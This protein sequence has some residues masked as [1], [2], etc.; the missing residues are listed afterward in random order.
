[1]PKYDYE[2]EN[3][4]YK[5]IDIYQ[6]F[7]SESLIKCINCGQD[8]LNKIIY[9]PHI[10][11]KGEAKTVAQLAE[12]NSKKMG[13]TLVDEKTLKDKEDKKEALKDAK[14]EMRAKI[15]KMSSDQ[16]RRYIEDGKI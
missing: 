14:K 5:I 9:C 15:N 10:S 13:K 3:C 6:S 2:C 1:M 16:S 4:N 7:D 12:R 8:S 11:I